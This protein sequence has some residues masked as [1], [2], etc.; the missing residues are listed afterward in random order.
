MG[1]C[2]GLVQMLYAQDNNWQ[3]KDPET[4]KIMG[5]STE[6]AYSELLKNKKPKE[7]IVAVID[8][9]IDTMQEDLKSVLWVNKKEKPGND[10]D[11]DRN[12]YVDDVH[13]WNFIGGKKGNVEYDNQEQTRIIRQDRALYDSLA[14]VG[15][16]QKD[17]SGYRSYVVIRKDYERDLVYTQSLAENA[18]NFKAVLDS[19]LV[20]I[21]KENPTID[22]FIK[23][24]DRAI[25]AQEKK[26]C[27]QTIDQLKNQLNFSKFYKEQILAGCNFFR[28][29]LDYHMNPDYDPRAIVG[30]H[31]YNDQEKHYG[32]NDV[33]G[34]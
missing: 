28:N 31:Y 4:D 33:C 3:H 6:K 25:N 32:N 30:D 16:P 27:S 12:G 11:D 18:R 5:I 13:G 21:G 10:K 24:R 17:L 22:D 15:I 34:P 20:K 14:T 23:Y 26:I 8:G 2:T 29:E 19:V 9:G 7:I 1:I